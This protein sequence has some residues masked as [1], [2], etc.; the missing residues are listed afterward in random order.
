[1][2]TSA[3]VFCASSES[4]ACLFVISFEFI[5]MILSSFCLGVL[6]AVVGACGVA[7]FVVLVAVVVAV[8]VGV[9]LVFDCGLYV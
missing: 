3:F 5:W 1:M 2:M 4:S 9:L 8:G 7:C 6:L